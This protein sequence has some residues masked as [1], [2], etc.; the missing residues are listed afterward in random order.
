M[1]FIYLFLVLLLVSTGAA[2]H[3]YGGSMTFSPRRNSDGTYKVEFRFKETYHSCN[4][5]NTWGCRSGDCGNENSFAIGQVDSSPNG[6]NWCQ[7]EGVITKTI[8]SN[9]Q[10]ELIKSSCCWIYNTVTNGG[11][12]SLLTYIDLGVRS[13]T[14]DPNRSPITTTLPLIRVPQNCPRRYNLLSFDPDGDQVRCRYGL[15]HNSECGVCNQPAGFTL[16][17]SSCSLSYDYTWLP[18]VYSF[19]LVLEDFPKHRITLSYTNQP[20]VTRSPISVIRDRRSNNGNPNQQPPVQHPNNGPVYNGYNHFTY[21][22]SPVY[23][24][25]NHFTYY[26]SPVY[27][28]YNHFTYYNHA[29][30]D[31]NH[32]AY[33]YSR[34]YNGYNYFTYYNHASNDYNHITYYYS[35]SGLQWLQPL[36][37]LQPRLQ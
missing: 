16:D 37:L 33:N 31:Y 14:S 34:V 19:E 36:Y 30:N 15:R 1:F 21:Y 13:D 20:S 17:Q 35:P 27:N 9:N 18:G 7:S 4:Q 29:S 12:W 5:Y 26:Y 23:N 24:G 22:Y 32:I 11:D 8:S 2:S 6:G 10:F 3:F 28:V 25:Y